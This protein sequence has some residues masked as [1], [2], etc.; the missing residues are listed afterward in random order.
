MIRFTLNDLISR[1]HGNARKKEHKLEI[2]VQ[3]LLNFADQNAVH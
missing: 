1:I 3:F 2:L